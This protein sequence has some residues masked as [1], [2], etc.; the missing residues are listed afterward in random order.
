[1]KTDPTYLGSVQRVVGARVA[2]EISSA[3][4]SSSP[5]ING[6]VHRVGQI[7]SLVRVPLGFVEVFGIVSMVG[8]APIDEGAEE[9]YAINREPSDLDGRTWSD[10]LKGF[11]FRNQ[12][13]RPGQ[14][15]SWRHKADGSDVAP[16]R[17]RGGVVS[18]RRHQT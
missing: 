1:M 5:I 14:M 10:I 18:D 13:S 15:S 8:A 7:G 3:L 17:L 16:G 2:V 9:L 11:G 4:P 12:R 6:R